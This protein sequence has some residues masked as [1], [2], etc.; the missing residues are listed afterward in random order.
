MPVMELAPPP[1]APVIGS[2]EIEPEGVVSGAGKGLFKGMLGEGLL[3]G[4]IG[5]GFSGL[6]VGLDM[7]TSGGANT[8]GIIAGTGIMGDPSHGISYLHFTEHLAG[9][10]AAAGGLYGA[11]KGAYEGVSEAREHNQR[12]IGERPREAA[13]S[14]ELAVALQQAHVPGFAPGPEYDAGYVGP[15]AMTTELAQYEN[16]PTP[17]HAQEIL[18][19]GPGRGAASHVG[20]YLA[21]ASLGDRYPAR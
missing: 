2:V 7:L 9:L 3:A 6:L 20:N 5:L 4:A 15:H 1:S 8:G 12:S 14:P 11:G 17:R 16:P 10:H 19:R 13:M 18:A 21:E